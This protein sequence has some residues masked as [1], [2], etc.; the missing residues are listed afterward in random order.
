MYHISVTLFT[1]FVAHRDIM[2]RVATFVANCD[3]AAAATV[4][5]ELDEHGDQQALVGSGEVEQEVETCAICLDAMSDVRYLGCGHGF[6]R[7][8]LKSWL[9]HGANENCPICRREICTPLIFDVLQAGH[10]FMLLHCTYDVICWWRWWSF[11]FFPAGLFCCLVIDTHWH[12]HGFSGYIRAAIMR[13]AQ[14]R[15]FF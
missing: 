6:C 13:V 14:V 2:K 3:F 1:Q 8:C 15:L 5:A 4:N 11:L 9:D 7:D 10:L 12:T